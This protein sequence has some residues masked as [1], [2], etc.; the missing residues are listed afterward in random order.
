MVLLINDAYI[1][2]YYMD[3]TWSVTLGHSYF[4]DPCYLVMKI[5]VSTVIQHLDTAIVTG[6]QVYTFVKFFPGVVGYNSCGMACHCNL[7]MVNLSH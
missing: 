7:A 6:L 4:A 5:W 3:G 1:L 2:Y